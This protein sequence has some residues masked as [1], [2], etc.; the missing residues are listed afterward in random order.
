MATYVYV[1]VWGSEN[2]VGMVVVPS[3]IPTDPKSASREL[4]SF[5]VTTLDVFP[6]V[7]HPWRSQCDNCRKLISPRLGDV[8]NGHHPCKYCSKKLQTLSQRIDADV[9][10]SEMREANLKPLDPYPGAGKPWKSKCL[11]CHRIGS[12]RLASIRRGHIGCRSCGNIGRGMTDA[13][14][15]SQ[16][17]IKIGKVVPLIEYP[18]NAKP[19]RCRCIRCGSEVTPVYSS[20]VSSGRGGCRFCG[21]KEGAKT[22]TTPA[23][24]AVKEMIK[25]GATPIAPFTNTKTPWKSKCNNCGNTI[26]PTLGN[27]RSGSGPCKFC[28]EH[29]F[30]Y[31]KKA[32]VY[33]LKHPIE[34]AYK[35]GVAGVETGRIK[36]L[37]KLGWEVIRIAEV[38][39]GSAA[40]KIESKILAKLI[41]SGAKIGHVPKS[42]MP[43]GGHTETIDM[44]TISRSNL[45]K[46]FTHEIGQSPVKNYDQILKS[47][48]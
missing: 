3:G 35:V 23:I 30:N 4:K 11:V 32:F 26:F 9:A 40:I 18:G 45:I 24:Q 47:L 16:A 34:S 22:R 28:A 38:R 19:W 12:P 41:L 21:K 36:M 15:A 2:L 46:I 39:K 42:R 1:A 13:N 25:N 31:R 44:K 5:G 20:V 10:M 6:G 33:L 29:G 43:R 48:T 37:T 7:K 8:R 14:L 27:T 17:M